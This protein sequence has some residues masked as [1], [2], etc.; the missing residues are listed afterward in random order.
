MHLASFFSCKRFL[1]TGNDVITIIALRGHQVKSEWVFLKGRPDLYLRFDFSFRSYRCRITN[2]CIPTRKDLDFRFT[3]MPG[4]DAKWMLN[5]V[6]NTKFFCIS[7]RLAVIHC[8]H[9]KR[10]LH[11]ESKIWGF[12]LHTLKFDL[13]L[14]KTE[15]TCSFAAKHFLSQHTSFCVA[16][17]GLCVNLRKFDEKIN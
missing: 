8:F 4:G 11:C 6:V 16:P 2:V 14:T 13:I 5:H 12:L 3:G 17:F 1:L 9:F 10:N 7:Y 15:K